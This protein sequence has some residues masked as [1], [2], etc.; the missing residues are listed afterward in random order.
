MSPV[1][2]QDPRGAFTGARNALLSGT[3]T[4]FFAPGLRGPLSVKAIFSGAGVWETGGRAFVVR[5]NSYLVVHRDQPYSF[6][7]DSVAPTTTLSVFFQHGFVETVH[8]D[9]TRPDRAVLDA[10]GSAAAGSLE[11]P[12]HLAPSPSRVLD[13]LRML[14]DANAR[15]RASATGME[16][17]FLRI[18]RALVGELPR[19][20]ESAF[21]LSCVR[22][23]TRRELMARVLRGRD[24][25][26]SRMDERVSVADAARAACM[27]QY[28]FF[29]TFR[30]AFRAT[31][32]QF[33]TLQRLER[34]RT[35]LRGGRH[36]VTEACMASGFQSVGSFSAL[37]RRHFGVPPSAERR[38]R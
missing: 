25:L 7:I 18:G 34:A 27:S 37:F 26:I 16:E 20:D 33:L 12:A 31:P 14:Y 6:G 35:L 4:D 13:A 17:A 9:V 1:P 29:R 32:H 28:H 23:S 30:E 21:R 10:A 22:A 24:C 5:E 3:T 15:G 36:S 19:L 2:S 38:R 8:R 11:W